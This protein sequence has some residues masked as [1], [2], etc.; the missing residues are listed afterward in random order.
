MLATLRP[1]GMPGSLPSLRS[2]KM[3]RPT[4][5]PAAS[6]RIAWMYCEERVFATYIV[7]SSGDSAS[8]LEYSQCQHAHTSVRRQAIDAGAFP[9]IVLPLWV[10]DLTL[11]EGE[12][13][14]P[15]GVICIPHPLH[16]HPL[17]PL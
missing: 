1:S 4:M 9:K 17:P 13:L 5:L 16:D 2:A 10:V 12:T 15:I 11:G 7:R 6:S 3:L 14:V 8:P